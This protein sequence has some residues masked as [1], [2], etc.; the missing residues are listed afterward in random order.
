MEGF[1][2]RMDGSMNHMGVTWQ[3]HT[4]HYSEQYFSFIFAIFPLTLLGTSIH[5]RMKNVHPP[6]D[7]SG[8]LMNVILNMS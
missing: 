4:P 7:R 1:G 3:Y 2:E 6:H 8:A 5:S